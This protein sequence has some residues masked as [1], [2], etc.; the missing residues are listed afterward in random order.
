MTRKQGCSQQN[1][2]LIWAARAWRTSEVRV[3]A[4]ATADLRVIGAHCA[5]AEFHIWKTTSC[6]D[7][8]W[9]QR[10]LVK[11]QRPCTDCLS[12]TRGP[13]EFSASTIHLRSE[14]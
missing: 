6:V 11:G 10:R 2:T 7:D 1:T 9:I 13:T 12:E 14:Q 8:S 4:P 5:T 3:I